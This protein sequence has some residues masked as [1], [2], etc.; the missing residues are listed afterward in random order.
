[1]LK[2]WKIRLILFWSAISLFACLFLAWCWNSSSETSQIT[3]GW[4]NLVYKGKIKLEK[5]PLTTD[6]LDE[7]IDLYQEVWE[8]TGFKDSLLIAENYSQWLGIN[9][10]AQDNLDILKERWLSLSKVNK[11]QIPLKD[12]G[13]NVNAV[14]VE[15]EIISWLLEELPVLYVSQ[16]F[17]PNDNDVVLMSFITEDKRSR[18][19]ASTMFKNLY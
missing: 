10:F 3:V 2:I 19:D 13:K 4:F 18:S 15:Y 1:M 16:L 6:D 17:V 12:S 11:F 14:L 5:I 8:E 9:A 7:I